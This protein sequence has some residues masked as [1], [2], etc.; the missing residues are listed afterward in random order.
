MTKVDQSPVRYRQVDQQRISELLAWMADGGRSSSSARGIFDHICAQFCEA[1]VPIDRFVLFFFII[2]PHIGGRRRTWE[3]GNSAEMS[4]APHEMISSPRIQQS[5]AVEVMKSGVT[6]RQKL[7][8]ARDALAFE[9]HIELK[10]RGLIDVVLQPLP[11][12]TGGIHAVSWATK[13]E[14][15]FTDDLVEVLER[16]RPL[17][18][19]L[20]EIYILRLHAA[21]LLN[22]FVGRDGGERAI[23]GQ[24]ARGDTE[25]IE[26]AVQFAD[27]K[28][29]TRLSTRVENV[30]V[31]ET[32]NRF[33]PY[34]S[35]VRSA[36]P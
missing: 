13:A 33:F 18:A 8:V 7:T 30:I 28:E 35:R 9:D 23:A 27:F 11:F 24:I 12:T 6:L 1:G 17:L 3:R 29:F 32:L 2:Q 10:E 31:I 16:V 21:S 15:G 34:P 5:P 4:S 20:A 26:A 19:R 22:A 14:A 36:E 25:V